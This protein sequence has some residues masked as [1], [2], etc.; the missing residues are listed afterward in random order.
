MLEVVRAVPWPAWAAT[1]LVLVCLLG[2]VRW[3]RR[4]R[5]PDESE[6]AGIE[7]ES[8]LLPVVTISVAELERDYKQRRKALVARLG[9][10][11]GRTTVLE[12]RTYETFPAEKVLA[13]A[14]RAEKAN[15]AAILGQP[16]LGSGRELVK[17]LGRAGSHVVGRLIRKGEGV[18]YA[19]VARDVAGHL[20]VR[21]LS[22]ATSIWEIEE[23]V[24]DAVLKEMEDNASPEVTAVIRADRQRSGAGTGVSIGAAA[25]TLAA[26]NLPG[27]ALYTTASTALSAV[28]GAVGVTLPFAAYTG[29]S[30][31]LATIT[32]PVGI[33]A[34]GAWAVLRLGRVDYRKTTPGVLLI[35]TVRRRLVAERDEELQALATEQEALQPDVR[36][37]DRLRKFL[38]KVRHLGPEHGVPIHDLPAWA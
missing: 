22:P 25:G 5:P 28:S 2:I 27:F 14:S 1:G 38:D 31:V 24:V 17:Q 20:G 9:K 7:Q 10:I 12:K 21:K 15:L 36:A 32:G 19:E 6:A 35:A 29:M 8:R 26:L 30:S 16:A 11:K 34:V 3:L 13:S 4:R 23:S 33:A 18:P 37:M